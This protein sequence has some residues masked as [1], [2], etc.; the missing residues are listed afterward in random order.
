MNRIYIFLSLVMI[1]N[2]CNSKN[3]TLIWSDDF[4]DSGEPDISKWTLITGNGCPELCGFGN[5]ELQYYTR[6]KEN[7]WLEDGNLFIQATRDTIGDQMYRSAKLITKD[8]GDWKY[9][10]IEVRAK[11][12]SGK[13]TWPAVWMLPSQKSDL[14]WP[15]DGEIDIMEHVGYN[16]GWVYGTVHT[17]LFNGMI[18]TQVTD[19]IYVDNLYSEFNTYSIEWDPRSIKWF[20]NDRQYNEISRK[21]MKKSWPFDKPFHLIINLAIGGDWGGKYGVDQDIWPQQ[22]VVDYV[23]VYQ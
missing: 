13:G 20:I 22:L 8:K 5:N 18:G 1:M 19:S 4:E 3:Q 9:G 2:A 15:E 11:L 7:V 12:P 10:K 23:K 21:K 6:H 17:E 16:P 14:N